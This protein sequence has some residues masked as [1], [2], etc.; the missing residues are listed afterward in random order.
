MYYVHVFIL[1]L[2]MCQSWGFGRLV[3]SPHRFASVS[4]PEPWVCQ[5]M[6]TNYEYEGNIINRSVNHKLT[7]QF[8]KFN[9]RRTMWLCLRTWTNLRCLISRLSIFNKKSGIF[10]CM[11]RVA[12]S[13]VPRH[14]EWLIT[15]P[16]DSTDVMISETVH[17]FTASSSILTTQ[18]WS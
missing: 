2:N 11:A 17:S 6:E 1:S 13:S 18:Q 7:R 5:T 9:D 12:E 10:I 16:M 15:L 8:D 4:Y 14:G 3:V